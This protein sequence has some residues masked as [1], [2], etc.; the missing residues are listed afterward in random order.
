SRL[1][2]TTPPYEPLPRIAEG[3]LMLL[4]GQ[5]PEHQADHADLDLGLARA[6][7][8][9][10]VSAVDPA[11]PQPGEGPFHDPAPLDHLE[12]LA[13]G[14]ASYHLDRV[15]AILGVPIVTA[16]KPTNLVQG[17]SSTAVFLLETRLRGLESRNR[18]LEE[19]SRTQNLGGHVVSPEGLGASRL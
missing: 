4:T 13:V 5:A 7:L 10:V 8:P 16:K 14:R 11:S 6:R 15:P 1:I 17:P 2:P 9:L 3:G 18:F 12:G 19:L